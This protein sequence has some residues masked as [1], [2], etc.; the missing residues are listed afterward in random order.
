MHS[1]LDSVLNTSFQALQKLTW[2]SCSCLIAQ[3]Q[4]Y[5]DE[6]LLLHVLQGTPDLLY[7]TEMLLNKRSDVSYMKIRKIFIFQRSPLFLVNKPL[8]GHW[9]KPF[10]LSNAYLA[11]L[12]I[13]EVSVIAK[14]NMSTNFISHYIVLKFLKLVSSYELQDLYTI[15]TM[16]ILPKKIF[17]CPIPSYL[18]GLR[19][20][21]TLFKK[22]FLTTE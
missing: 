7:F 12:S 10:F 17:R 13:L 5:F 9:T 18:L 19:L 21:A 8:S 16:F 20:D 14:L 2:T 1:L 4:I 3:P 6:G 15:Y 22:V 11:S